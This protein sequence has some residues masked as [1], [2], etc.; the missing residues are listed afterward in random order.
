MESLEIKGQDVKKR[1]DFGQAKLIG[2]ISLWFAFVAF[3][4]LIIVFF[5]VASPSESYQ[6]NIKSLSISQQNLPWV[7][8]TTGLILLLITAIITWMVSL[9]SSFRITG[10]L[11]RFSR[12]IEEWVVSG[13]PKAI[14][15]RT[16]DSL[17][18]ESQLMVESI[19][20][21]YDYIDGFDPVIERAL[22]AADKGDIDTLNQQLHQL[23]S[24]EQKATTDARAQ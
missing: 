3:I 1:T 13:K 11:F 7:M 17:Q 22:E 2:K 20:V 14:P 5:T 15:V 16:E 10:P 21:L 19:K 8:L 9:Y 6:Q 24:M 18:E 23:K 4:G 12:N